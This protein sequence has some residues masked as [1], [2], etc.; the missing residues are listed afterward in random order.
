MESVKVRRLLR[1]IRLATNLLEA[2]AMPGEPTSSEVAALNAP[3][4]PLVLNMSNVP[5]L[6]S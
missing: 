1:D 2:G 6:V 5:L 3:P 4:I